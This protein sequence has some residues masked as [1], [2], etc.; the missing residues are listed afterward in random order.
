MPEDTDDRIRP[1]YR[2]GHRPGIQHV[3]AD[4]RHAGADGSDLSGRPRQRSYL[5]AGRE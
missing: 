1:G 2:F 4:Y 3:S 5:V